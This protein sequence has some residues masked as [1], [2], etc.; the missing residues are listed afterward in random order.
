MHWDLFCGLACDLSWRIFY[1]HLKRMSI[2]LFDGIF[3]IWLLSPSYLIYCLVDI[4]LLTFCLDNLYIAIS[5]V[6]KSPTMIVLLPN[7]LFRMLTFALY[8]EVLLSWGHI[9][10]QLLYLLIGLTPWVLCNVLLC[11][12]LTV[13]V[14][15]SILCHVAIPE[16]IKTQASS[17]CCLQETLQL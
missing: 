17:I 16:W 1:M 13:F 8:T 12:M 9:Y 10:L 15:K 4:F 11:L 2:L 14:L 3:C 7:S 6:L 5:G